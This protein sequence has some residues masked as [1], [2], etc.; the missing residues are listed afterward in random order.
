METQAILESYLGLMVDRKKIGI[1]ME[2]AA[3]PSAITT[4]SPEGGYIITMPYHDT[5]FFQKYSDEEYLKVAVGLL[6]HEIAHVIWTQREYF[7]R[8]RKSKLYNTLLS[9]MEDGRIEHKFKK[10]LPNGSLWLDYM[11]I[12]LF[13]PIEVKTEFTLSD[14][15]ELIMYRVI[16]SYIPDIRNVQLSHVFHKVDAIIQGVYTCPDTNAVAKKVSKMVDIIVKYFPEAKRSSLDTILEAWSNPIIARAFCT[17]DSH[18][19]CQYPSIS[20]DVIDILTPSNNDAEAELIHESDKVAIKIMDNEIAGDV[21][22]G[23]HSRSRGVVEPMIT[24]PSSID[25]IDMSKNYLLNTV[26]NPTQLITDEGH[27][28]STSRSILERTLH[29][30]EERFKYKIKG[31]HGKVDTKRLHR[32][33]TTNSTNLYIQR[34]SH[35]MVD[36]SV[37]ILLDLSSSMKYDTEVLY[38]MAL[39]L[40]HILHDFR[41]IKFAIYGFNQ[42]YTSISVPEAIM[43]LHVLKPYYDLPQFLI[44]S[45]LLQINK[46]LMDGSTPMAEALEFAYKQQGALFPQSARVLFV[47]TDGE[48][49]DLQCTKYQIEQC[50]SSIYAIYYSQDEASNSLYELFG[51]RLSTAHSYSLVVNDIILQLETFIRSVY[52]NQI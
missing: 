40:Y 30:I 47:V 26:S 4:L 20:P 48:P 28:I 8:G 27:F 34:R 45:N 39:S 32:V 15:I 18:L 1:R 51:S 9:V 23:I 52:D 21:L 25:I 43:R 12:R 49:N 2:S 5:P 46:Q 17:S 50:T 41:G 31:R 29:Y 6:N 24:P 36:V 16:M 11:N 38:K 33:I 22:K 19:L 42:S 7:V 14:L 37:T 44:A 13:P 10:H 3:Y 35:T